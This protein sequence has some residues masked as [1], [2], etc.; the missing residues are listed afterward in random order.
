[1]ELP[2]RE[3]VSRSGKFDKEVQIVAHWLIEEGLRFN[4]FLATK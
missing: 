4:P 3:A 1:M 2:E